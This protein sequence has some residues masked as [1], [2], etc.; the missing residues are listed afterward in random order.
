MSGFIDIEE[1]QEN[2]PMENEGSLL[3]KRQFEIIKLMSTG[4]TQKEISVKL[5][6]S[7]RTVENYL[8]SAYQQIGARNKVEAINH[9]RKLKRK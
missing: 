3:S 5:N 2:I 7:K 6:L 9:I 1:M 4:L 8:Y